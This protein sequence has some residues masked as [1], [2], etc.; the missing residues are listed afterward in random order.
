MAFGFGRVLRPTLPALSEMRRGSWIQC[1]RVLHQL[2]ARIHRP[3]AYLSSRG[4]LQGL[5][6]RTTV[7]IQDALLPFLHPPLAPSLFSISSATFSK[8]LSSPARASARP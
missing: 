4:P 7:Q 8:S 2:R 3:T 5:L 1:P 6:R